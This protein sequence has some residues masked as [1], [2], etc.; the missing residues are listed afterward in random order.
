MRKSYLYSTIVLIIGVWLVLPA[1]TAVAQST[2]KPVV[3]A[4]LFFSPACPHCHTIINDVLI[5]M[6][7]EQGESLQIIGVDT[8]K[9]NG[10]QLYQAAIEYY[11][12]PSERRGVPTLIIGEVILVGSVEIPKQF[13][14]L[15]KEGLATGGIDW[16]DIPG[17]VQ[18]I[19]PEA[20][21][22]PT[23]TLVTEATSVPPAT[24]T[25]NPTAT[26]QASVTPTATLTPIPVALTLGQDK[27]ALSETETTQ[28]DPAGF[29]LAGII[30][31][32]MVVALGF[33]A[34]RV[35]LGLKRLPRL[36]GA[37]AP[38][39]TSSAIPL[40][41]LAGLGIAA[42]LAYVEITHVAAS[43][44]PVGNCNIVQ[45]SEYAQIFG[46]PVAMLGILNY[47]AIALLWAGQFAS[48]YRRAN[49]STL[50][51]LGLT[52]FGTLFSIYLT[53][54]ELFVIHA[55]CIWCLSSAV[56]TTLL[57]VLIVEPI[58]H[59][60]SAKESPSFSG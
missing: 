17:L 56:I 33:A 32:A 37:P 22:A 14:G 8:T 21:Q 45:S 30:M 46:V 28:S 47:A 26:R 23:P 29:T 27:L 13:P 20:Q 36:E 31:A 35:T 10:S 9:P 3:Q 43:C 50:G 1:V 4:V 34:W 59:Y 58:T 24:A 55:V 54:L 49:F 5:P 51:L 57:M 11:Q 18:I 15:V 6:L 2:D 44:G 7:D 53:L 19:P 16:P 12:I 60:P 25:H 42:Y 48:D 41:A 52:L 38:H 40:L 39:A